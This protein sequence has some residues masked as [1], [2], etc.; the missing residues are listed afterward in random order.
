V[1]VHI[2]LGRARDDLTEGERRELGE[3]IA[4]LSTVPGVRDFTWGPDFSGRGK[5]YTHG[6][7]MQFANRAALDAYQTNEH[8]RAVVAILGRLLIDKLVVDYET[9]SSGISS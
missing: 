6:A 9:G 1:I 5:G 2:L 3:A 8:H 7:V 4:S